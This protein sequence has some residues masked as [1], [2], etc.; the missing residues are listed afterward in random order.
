MSEPSPDLSDFLSFGSDEDSTPR[1][2]WAPLPNGQPRP[3]S[4]VS[5]NARRRSSRKSKKQSPVTPPNAARLSAVGAVASFPNGRPQDPDSKTKLSNGAGVQ[6]L[7]ERRLAN[8]L[9]MDEQANGGV[10][11]AM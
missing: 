10:A 2:S 9:L 6:L 3:D 5:P 7:D 8:A 11:W 4:S 1:S